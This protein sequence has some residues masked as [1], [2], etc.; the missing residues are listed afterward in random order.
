MADFFISAGE[1]SGDFYGA[2]LIAALRQRQP[3]ALFFGLGG[4]AMR[5]AGCE[6]VVHASSVAAVGITEVLTRIP[7]TLAAYRYLLREAARRRPT[8][9]I[10]IDFPD[11]N[12]RLAARL[13][14]RGV[15][16]IYFVSP[17][18][19]AWKQGRIETIRRYVRKMLVIFPFEVAFYRRHGMEVEYVGHPLAD[20]P[21]PQPPSDFLGLHGLAEAGHTI[22]LLP[23]SR[24]GEV[25]RILPTMLRAAALLPGKNRFLVP[26]ASTLDP[27]WVTDI[28]HG[29]TQHLAT[30]STVGVTRDARAALYQARAAAVASG[31][32]TVEAALIGTPFVMVYR[33]SPLTWRLG[34]PLVKVPHYA[35]VNLVAGERVVPELMQSDFTPKALASRLTALLAEG[36]ARERMIQELAKVRSR[37]HSPQQESGASAFQ[38][39]ADSVL[40]AVG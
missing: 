32:A 23:G 11:V 8:A 13:A 26:V 38:R 18:V 12:L 5:D 27:Q 33:V 19:W 34:R 17:Q 10:L 14:R 9:A 4:D 31:T 39:A 3:Q 15:P 40:Q 20:L 6:L 21:L 28:V 25:R 2:G 37:L 35:M 24:R 7:A 1:A 30:L 22:A 36:P 16:V 29:E